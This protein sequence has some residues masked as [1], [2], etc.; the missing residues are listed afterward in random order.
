VAQEYATW[1][2]RHHF[3]VA[4]S[5]IITGNGFVLSHTNPSRVFSQAG[6]V[7]STSTPYQAAPGLHLAPA[8]QHRLAQLFMESFRRWSLTRSMRFE[9]PTNPAVA[10]LQVDTGF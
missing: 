7:T 10:Y 1:Q 6:A 5:V 2:M 4:Y 3:R 9:P 8:L